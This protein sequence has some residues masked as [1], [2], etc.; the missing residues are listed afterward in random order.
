MLFG[1]S[2]Y[3]VRFIFNIDNFISFEGQVSFSTSLKNGQSCPVSLFP[4]ATYCKP[5]GLVTEFLAI[6]NRFTYRFESQL[7]TWAVR[8][9]GGKLWGY[10]KRCAVSFYNRGELIT[11]FKGTT[12]LMESSLECTTS[13]QTPWK[14]NQVL[15]VQLMQ[16][17]LKRIRAFHRTSNQLWSL[18]IHYLVLWVR[19]RLEA[20]ALW[21]PPVLALVSYTSVYLF[22]DRLCCDLVWTTSCSLSSS[23][24]T[25]GSIL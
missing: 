18:S 3:E 17:F 24:W 8:I 21:S 11:V 5:G 19:S 12:I 10:S 22:A 16:G 13:A 7:L 23:K 2:W 6:V 14:F 20:T 9:F 15:V 25:W 4:G 1:S